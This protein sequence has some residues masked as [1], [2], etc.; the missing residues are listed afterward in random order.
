MP[1]TVSAPAASIQRS[2]SPRAADPLDDLTL[3]SLPCCSPAGKARHGDD[4]ILGRYLYEISRYPLLTR[5]QEID[6]AR[7][8]KAGDENA[9]EELAK[10]NLRF[11]VSVAKNYLWQSDDL[12][13][14]DLISEGNAG[15]VKAAHR[16]D[17]KR[18]FRFITYAV[19]W[20][21]QAIL[22][23]IADN[24]NPLRVAANA[25]KDLNHLRAAMAHAQ[26][27]LGREPGSEELLKQ[28]IEDRLEVMRS[29]AFKKGRSVPSRREIAAL[30]KHVKWYWT[31]ER[32]KDVI[33]IPNP[34][35]V[36]PLQSSSGEDEGSRALEETIEDH[37]S[38]ADGIAEMESTRLGLAKLLSILNPREQRVITEYYGLDGNLGMTLEEIGQDMGLT[39]E[40][41]RQIKEGALEKLRASPMPIRASLEE[42]WRS[43]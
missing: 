34:R 25:Q 20:I 26:N 23:A 10:A 33:S 24:P 13:L 15:L 2:K 38:S 40:R 4:P 8:I 41:I 14:L 17:E 35:R 1:R 3:P 43:G 21:R 9:L 37:G 19:W 18:G 6:L 36:L 27:A 22:Q 5:E 31:D 29:E 16:F 28:L 7:R 12:S 30:R 11:V 39:R 42:D 32:L